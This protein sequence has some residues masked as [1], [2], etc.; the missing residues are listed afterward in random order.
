MPYFA[1]QWTWVSCQHVSLIADSTPQQGHEQFLCWQDSCKWSETNFQGLT[2]IT[3]GLE[4]HLD[5]NYQKSTAKSSITGNNLHFVTVFI[6][7]CAPV[8]TSLGLSVGRK[9]GC[10]EK[11]V[12][13]PLPCFLTKVKTWGDTAATLFL[14]LTRPESIVIAWK[15]CLL[16]DNPCTLGSYWMGLFFL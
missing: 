13:E 6:D 14:C 16:F 12:A 3:T 7:A 4:E 2:N 8:H 15:K 5:R 10:G 1:G 9:Y 11:G